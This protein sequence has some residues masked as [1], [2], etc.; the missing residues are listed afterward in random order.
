M[1]KE[2]LLDKKQYD[3][4]VAEEVASRHYYFSSNFNYEDKKT[5]TDNDKREVRNAKSLIY[6]Q[7][8][9]E[10]KTKHNKFWMDTMDT[11]NLKNL[12]NR[13]GLQVFRGNV[14]CADTGSYI[15]KA[16]LEQ[17]VIPAIEKEIGIT[18][19]RLKKR[20]SALS[21]S[22]LDFTFAEIKEEE[23]HNE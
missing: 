5:W 17:I 4:R 11:G 8:R 23:P 20:C 18:G 12:L 2:T 9:Q 6:H 1:T 13:F 14:R 15:I 19:I 7:M 10:L 21:N 16:F 22:L 3:K